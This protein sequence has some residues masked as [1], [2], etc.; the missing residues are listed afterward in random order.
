[1]ASIL[2]LEKCT[3]SARLDGCCGYSL[4]SS[5]EARHEE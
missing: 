2:S 1:M 3:F 5:F 4:P